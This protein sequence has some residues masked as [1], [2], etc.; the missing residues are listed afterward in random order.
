MTL[1]PKTS[2]E[3]EF[4]NILKSKHA[5]YIDGARVIDKDK[6]AADYLAPGAVI[7]KITDSAKYG[8]VTRGEL[9]TVDNSANTFTLNAEAFNFQVG[10]VLET[11]DADGVIEENASDDLTVTA[12]DGAVL[13]VNNIE[14]T[15]H[16]A[17]LF[18]Q[19]ADG[20]SKAEFIC[21]EMVDV[22][23]EDAIVGG[24]VHG[25]VYADR[26]PNYDEKVAAD[27]PM[28]SFE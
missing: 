2:E 17:A 5:R 25:A 8:P 20:T 7:G 27:L 24:I 10:D 28:I 1:K 4:I 13:T 18:V 15:E 26:L 11:L 12:V 23:E 21:T 9:D 6:V 19:K 3:L 16:D 14:S 22:S